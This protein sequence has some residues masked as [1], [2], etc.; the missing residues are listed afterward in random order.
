MIYVVFI[1]FLFI[2]PIFSL[3]T[4]Q[5]ILMIMARV[6]REY[7]LRTTTVPVYLVYVENSKGKS[8]FPKYSVPFG[9]KVPKLWKSKIE[10]LKIVVN[11]VIIK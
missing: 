6:S 7:S 4:I 8:E 11:Q 2:L 5:T 1:L 10:I 9:P 3:G